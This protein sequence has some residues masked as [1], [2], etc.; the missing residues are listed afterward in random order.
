MAA[1][2]LPGFVDVDALE[3]P[4]NILLELLHG[5]HLLLQFL[6]HEVVELVVVDHPVAVEVDP[7]EVVLQFGGVGANPDRLQSLLQFCLVQRIVFV[8][9]QASE[10]LPN[11]LLQSSR[12]LDI[13]RVPFKTLLRLENQLKLLHCQDSIPTRIQIVEQQLD[14]LST[15]THFPLQSHHFF[16]K[17]LQC[18]C[19]RRTQ[20]KEVIVDLVLAST[21][22][23][24]QFHQL[25]RFCYFLLC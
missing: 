12:Y 4:A 25:L 22:L 1:G 8:H 10:Q 13:L 24:Y 14:L 23:F 5:D 18:Y 11:L 21:L 3:L 7:A 17:H 9:V 15:Y 19:T 2:E 20:R 16:L 6:G